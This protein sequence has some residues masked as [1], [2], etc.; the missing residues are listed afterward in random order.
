MPR[1]RFEKKSMKE[2]GS[3]RSSSS[4]PTMIPAT[5][6]ITTTG[7]VRR[8]DRSAARRAASAAT[9]TITRKDSASTDVTIAAAP[10]YGEPRALGRAECLRLGLRRVHRGRFLGER[11]ARGVL[12]AHPAHHRLG[13][14]GGGGRTG[15]EARGR[16]LR[17]PG[18]GGE[19]P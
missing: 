13:G 7:T 19:K 17:R 15:G 4:G 5:I 2:S 6:S 16:L 8:G 14:R 18:S 11:P 10:A 12:D 9:V 1:P 3:A